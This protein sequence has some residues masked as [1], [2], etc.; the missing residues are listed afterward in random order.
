MKN[1][2]SSLPARYRIIILVLSIPM[3][4]ISQ[5][6]NRNPKP[7]ETSSLMREYRA[8]INRITDSTISEQKTFAD[9]VN[10]ALTQLSSRQCHQLRIYA[11]SL[12]LVY[13]DSLSSDGIDSLH[14]AETTY[15]YLL[16]AKRRA[17]TLPS[18]HLYEDVH[19]RFKHLQ[20]MYSTCDFCSSRDQF[21]NRI[22]EYR[23]VID[24]ISDV[25]RDS[26]L[27]LS[28]A[29]SQEMSDSLEAFRDNI[30]DLIKTFMSEDEEESPAPPASS[31][32]LSS[33][34]S[35]HVSYH[36]RDNGIYQSSLAP[37][38]LYTHASGW[39][40]SLSSSWVDKP[41][42]EHDQT[43]VEF[44]YGFDISSSISA[45]F[46]YS[47]FWFKD[48]S[49]NQRSVLDNTLAAAL[50]IDASVVSI[51]ATMA[52]DFAKKSELTFGLAAGR[53]FDFGRSWF[54]ESTIFTPSIGAVWGQQDEDIVVQRR[55][56]AVA[57]LNKKGIAIA[58]STTR[59]TKTFGILDYE[60]LLP[61]DL[62]SGSITVSPTLSYTFPM[63][64]L[65][66]SDVDPFLSGSL[67]VSI[68]FE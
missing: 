9:S 68:S 29:G 57:K 5:E 65:D 4:L 34:Y 53:E 64:V 43:D 8:L 33:L 36:G 10:N 52:V 50:S 60:I 14:A 28:D 11:D 67:T 46:S 39:F 12:A 17:L 1:Q 16:A 35:D 31:L 63:N 59:T 66:G 51:D 48:S 2:G 41:I 23:A 55:A 37:S 20:G 49:I 25:S 61:F 22:E 58:A 38:I 40:V 26:M 45:S 13:A 21:D 3:T 32:Q 47:H 18:L 54:F 19:S 24:S 42:R 7:Q 62:Q 6:Q 27:S 15:E 44:G 30:V 56:R